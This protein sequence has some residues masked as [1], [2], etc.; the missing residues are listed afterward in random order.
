MDKTQVAVIGAGP[1]GYAA[2]FR[3]AGLGLQV[4]LI[5]LEPNPGGVCLYRGCIPSKALLH[6]ARLLVEAEEARHWGIDFQPPAI[7][8]D[9]LRSWK[10]RVIAKMT[11]GLG[12]MAKLHKVRQLQGRARLLDAHTLRIQK[13][14]GG[15]EDLG[16]EHAILATGS[17]P[18]QIPAFEIGSPRVL[19]STSALQLESIPASLLVVGGSYIG[20]EMGTVYA[21]LGSQVSVVEMMPG[22]IP[23]ADRDLIKP[24]AARL[25]KRF[26]RIMLGA[27]VQ[28]LQERESD[29]EVRFEDGQGKVW[30]EVYEKVLVAVGRKPN[31]EDLGLENTRVKLTPRGFVEVDV[32]RRTAEPSIFAI[33]DLTGDPMLAHKA[34]HEAAVAAEV[35]AGHKAAF[36]PNAIPA[37]V[38]TDPE[39]AWCGLTETQ[40]QE[41]QRPIEIARFPWTAS[42]RATTL[43]RN[44]GLTKLILDPDTQRILGVG[45][46]G[47]GA[48]ELIGEATLAVE[49]AA[50][51][52]DLKLTIHPHPTLSETLM[53]AAEVFF[54]QS[55]HL[56]TPPK[57]K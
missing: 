1:G 19:D 4:A 3:A 6:V 12:Q 21:A 11:G 31:S 27:E 50:L 41:Q 30:T 46:A 32:Q 51:V 13:T 38:F 9:R 57:R 26:A 10:D 37:V 18:A 47:P 28:G 40:A 48:G 55:P 53:E 36:E 35:I 8:L 7:D 5:D 17:R 23:L 24:L 33:G 49:M 56:Y 16:F 2:A 39:I 22:L 15:E 54:G 34:S 29:L 44:E 45:I 43:D 14:A 20:L 52:T 25:E 42:G